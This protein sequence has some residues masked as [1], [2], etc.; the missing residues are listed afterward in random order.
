MC[1]LKQAQNIFKPK[2][3]TPTDSTLTFALFP[4]L[5]IL[6][7]SLHLHLVL[8]HYKVKVTCAQLHRC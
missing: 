7:A 2:A 5:S 3:N 4:T 1:Y 8:N 6:S